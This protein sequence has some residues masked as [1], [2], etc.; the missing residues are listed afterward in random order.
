MPG[1]NNKAVEEKEKIIR[2]LTLHLKA[3]KPWKNK[4]G[5]EYARGWNDCLKSVEKDHKEFLKFINSRY[6]KW[7]DNND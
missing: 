6:I 2:V 4:N 3:I 5:D 7:T 1:R